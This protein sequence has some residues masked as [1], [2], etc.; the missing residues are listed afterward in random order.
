MFTVRNNPQSSGFKGVQVVA[1]PGTN[2][3]EQET[4]I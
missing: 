2:V 4:T 3:T 1:Q